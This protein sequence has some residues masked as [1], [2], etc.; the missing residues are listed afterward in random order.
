[1]RYTCSSL[2]TKSSKCVGHDFLLALLTK[3]V[4]GSR[5]RW[6]SL[7]ITFFG[8]V[9]QPVSAIEHVRDT[10]P[11]P[12]CEHSLS[13]RTIYLGRVGPAHA[14]PYVWGLGCVTFLN[15]CLPLIRLVGAMEP[16]PLALLWLCHPLGTVF[17]LLALCQQQQVQLA[18]PAPPPLAQSLGTP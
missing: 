7:P 1:M 15:F 16:L 9:I 5:E 2:N 14:K 13:L 17:G 6:Q 3:V 11:A 18:A 12:T 4:L 10:Y 8:S